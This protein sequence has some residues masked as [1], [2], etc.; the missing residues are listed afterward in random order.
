MTVIHSPHLCQGPDWS[1][2][3]LVGNPNESHGYLTAG[4]F[5]LLIGEA[6]LLTE[7]GVHLGVEWVV[8]LLNRCMYVY[9]VCVWNLV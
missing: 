5:Q 6:I 2:H 4:H 1:A 7:E 3:G 9:D 8:R